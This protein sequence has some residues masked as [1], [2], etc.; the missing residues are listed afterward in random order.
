MITI[1]GNG[2]VPSGFNIVVGTCCNGPLVVFAVRVRLDVAATQPVSDRKQ[3]NIAFK[4]T[5]ITTSHE[6]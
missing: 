3:H 2:P 4:A 1:A 5:G 6:R